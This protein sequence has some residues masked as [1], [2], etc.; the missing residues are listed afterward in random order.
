M[1][2][3]LPQRSSTKVALS[4]RDSDWMASRPGMKDPGTQ[5]LNLNW[6]PKDPLHGYATGTLNA[7]QSD[8][9]VTIFRIVIPNTEA[10]AQGKP[11]RDI[12]DAVR[13]TYSGWVQDFQETLPYDGALT[14]VATICATGEPTRA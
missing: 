9:T 14:A 6:D 13:Y 10:G 5:A 4:D 7:M 11:A 8:G 3:N 2:T 1:D 12:T